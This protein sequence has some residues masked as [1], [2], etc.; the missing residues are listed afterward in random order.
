MKNLLRHNPLFE[1][2][3]QDFTVW[4]Y[5]PCISPSLKC[6]QNHPIGISV[7]I[8]PEARLR[9]IR[10]DVGAKVSCSVVGSTTETLILENQAPSTTSAKY[11][12][13]DYIQCDTDCQISCYVDEPEVQLR[14]GTIKGA[15][16]EAKKALG[17]DELGRLVFIN[18]QVLVCLPS[19]FPIMV[20]DVIKSTI[21]IYEIKSVSP[22]S[23]SQ[24]E[25]EFFECDVVQLFEPGARS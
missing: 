2:R 25:L 5:T 12:H 3:C 14:L 13:L 7:T 22:A 18:T 4:R 19:V 23:N 20:G 8:R 24:G 17:M 10:T 6:S 11:S 16:V 21:G 1:R 15:L 9:L